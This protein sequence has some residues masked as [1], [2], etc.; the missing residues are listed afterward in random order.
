MASKD[1]SKEA[2]E[3]FL[4]DLTKEQYAEL[5]QLADDLDLEVIE[6]VKG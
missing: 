2:I 1:L 4:Q 6:I 3:L 5:M